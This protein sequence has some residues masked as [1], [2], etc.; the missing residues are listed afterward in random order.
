MKPKLCVCSFPYIE[1]VYGV[2]DHVC[3]NA[4]VALDRIE[5]REA[6]LE[7]LGFENVTDEVTNDPRD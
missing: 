1:Y 2:Q 6:W 5:E 3:R 7:S 4:D